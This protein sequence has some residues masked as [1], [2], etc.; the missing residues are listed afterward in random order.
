MDVNMDVNNTDSKMFSDTPNVNTSVDHPQG[1]R[2]NAINNKDVN[3]A[4][5]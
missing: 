3:S 2:T 4:V 5:T 1:E